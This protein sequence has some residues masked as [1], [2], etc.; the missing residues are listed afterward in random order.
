MELTGLTEKK[1]LKGT[2]YYVDADDNIVAKQCSGC[3]HV[4]R[5]DEF[6]RKKDGL[7]GRESK[8]KTCSKGYYEDNR[9]RYAETNRNWRERN[10]EYMC[11]WYEANRDCPEYKQR[12][13]EYNRNWYEANKERKAET[14]R[15][16]KR[17]NADKCVL[18]NQRRRA[19]KR[20]LPNTLTEDQRQDIYDYFDGGCAFTGDTDDVHMDHVIPLATGHGG[21][22][23]G[24]I[25]PL[26]GD[27]NMS[28]GDRSLFEWFHANKEHYGL[29]QERFDRL[30]EY[31]A[32][33]NG[34]T[35]KEYEVYTRW[36]HDN[37][38]KFNEKLTS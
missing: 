9:E 6:N 34:M 14:D 35:T 12:K 16:W 24:N 32:D 7:G 10:P 23:Y 22:V 31:L 11:N 28:K 27:L 26:R 19:R 37:P 30:A 15:N 33:L 4:K 13:A 17:N 21:T 36:C 25:I 18:S 20:I 38:R 29:S 1:D 3:P 2:V 5:L 8:C